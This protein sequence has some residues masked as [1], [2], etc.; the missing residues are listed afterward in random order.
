MERK[1]HRQLK[2]GNRVIAKGVTSVRRCKGSRLGA[3]TK[4]F[5]LRDMCREYEY[6]SSEMTSILIRFKYFVVKLPAG[7]LNALVK[8]G[9]PR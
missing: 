6:I 8:I 4:S 1:T 9:G 3:H 7:Q 5:E 2:K